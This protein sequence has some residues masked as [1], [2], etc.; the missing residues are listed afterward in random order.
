MALPWN[1]EKL[2]TSYAQALE[3]GSL[4]LLL[5]LVTFLPRIFVSLRAAA[6]G[7]ILLQSCRIGGRADAAT[8]LA[9][10][11]LQYVNSIGD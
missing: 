3:F 11:G 7:P 5:A 1:M 4:A 2:L 6:A 8:C 10:E 9:V